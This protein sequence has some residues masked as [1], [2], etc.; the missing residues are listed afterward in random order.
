[1]GLVGSGSRT[2]PEQCS[3]LPHRGTICAAPG[4]AVKSVV[5]TSPRAG[6]GAMEP[7][8]TPRRRACSCP[9]RTPHRRSRT[10]RPASRHRRSDRALFVG[11]QGR[12]KTPDPEPLP[13]LRYRGGATP[14]PAPRARSSPQRRR[15]RARRGRRH[16]LRQRPSRASLDPVDHD[17]RAAERCPPPPHHAAAREVTRLPASLVVLPPFRFPPS[18]PSPAS[19]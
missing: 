16:R 4:P 6:R 18:L 9:A 5:S 11:R 1:L 17:L 12:L 3:L 15:P 7:G 19:F 8:Q 14:E 2:K 10:S 13:T